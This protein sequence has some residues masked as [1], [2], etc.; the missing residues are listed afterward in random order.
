[1]EQN[2]ID[3]IVREIDN[4]IR[5][6]DMNGRPRS[7]YEHEWQFYEN[8]VDKITA[9]L[10]ESEGIQ[11]SE[12]TL[13]RLSNYV[14]STLDP[15]EYGLH[16]D[17][18]YIIPFLLKDAP[19]LDT[20]GH[21]GQEDETIRELIGQ[22]VAWGADM[23]PRLNAAPTMDVAELIP[24][25]FQF[26]DIPEKQFRYADIIWVTTRLIS[27]AVLDDYVHEGTYKYRG[28][29][30]NNCITGWV[31]NW[32]HDDHT[33]VDWEEFHRAEATDIYE[34]DDVL[35]IARFMAR[36]TRV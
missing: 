35:D 34:D 7:S 17:H 16:V 12:G 3:L 28:K 2:R 13:Q 29:E 24:E 25:F 22:M 1:M 18:D 33:I 21:H 23:A 4:I 8:I 14:T 27:L 5:R 20:T 9:W 30:S 11:V 15:D 32:T 10:K 6:E 19:D 36:R 31:W 26:F